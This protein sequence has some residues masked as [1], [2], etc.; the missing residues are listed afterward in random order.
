MKQ[1][2][3]NNPEVRKLEENIVSKWGFKLLSP[4]AEDLDR[5]IKEFKAD[6]NYFLERIEDIINNQ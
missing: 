1:Q 6:L 2:I 4:T 5:N 3:I